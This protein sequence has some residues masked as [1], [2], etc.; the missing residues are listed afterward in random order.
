MLWHFVVILATYH[1]IRHTL[2]E[3]TAKSFHFSL[4]IV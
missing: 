3:K 1:Q 4:M 2:V